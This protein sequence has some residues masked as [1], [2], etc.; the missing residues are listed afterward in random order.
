MANTAGKQPASQSQGLQL[1]L[2]PPVSDYS[3][4]PSQP[5]TAARS[6]ASQPSSDDLRDLE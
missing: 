3:Q 2:L 5:H 4:P 6:N 1:R